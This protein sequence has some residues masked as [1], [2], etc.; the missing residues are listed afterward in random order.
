MRQMS[1]PRSDVEFAFERFHA[2]NPHVYELFCRFAFDVVEAGHRRFSAR[3]IWERMRWELRVQTRRRTGELKLND[4]YPPYY[5]R[6]FM[7]D[8]PECEGLFSLRRVKGD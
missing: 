1:L 7:A 5:A 3:T 6:K 8:H 4:H 2:A